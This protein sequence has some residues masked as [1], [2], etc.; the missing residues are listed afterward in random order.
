MMTD[1]NSIT[2]KSITAVPG[3]YV[4]KKIISKQKSIIKNLDKD[5]WFPL[6]NSTNSRKV[7]H[8]GYKY[9]YKSSSVR[10]IAPTLPSY[11]LNLQSTLTEVCKKFKIIN[12]T[13]EFNQCIVN[14]YNKG[15]AIS[16]HI[17][18]L[19]YGDVIGCY[20]VGNKTGTMIFTQG[21]KTIEVKAKPKC[22]YIMSGDAR[23]KWKHEMK[24]LGIFPKGHK[25]EGLE[26]RR[27]S[28]TFRN[29]P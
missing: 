28:I 16:K 12:N 25:K 7:Q 23:Y 22:L 29:V 27:I 20:S 1:I 24:N 14:N 11:L 10:D 26:P 17:D 21:N 2:I 13:Y 15:Q 4:C 3:L 19:S 6:S 8:Y 18:A 9:N 5:N